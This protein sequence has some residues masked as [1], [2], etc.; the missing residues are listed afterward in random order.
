MKILLVQSYL[1]GH[2]PP[3]YPAGL[4]CLLSVLADHD[5]RAFDPNTADDP[6]GG[7]EQAVREFGP[8]VVG[9]S[10]R[11]IDSTNKR[12]V[13]FY[14][15]FFKEML[16]QIRA[17]TNAPLIVGGSGFSMFAQ[18]IMED[19]PL[20]DYGVYLE[21]ERTFPLLLANLDAPERAPSVFYRRDGK[22][23]FSGG[24][25]KVGGEAL[26]RPNFGAAPLE[27]YLGMPWGVGVETKRG[28][29][30]SCIY[31]PY[32][33]LNGKTY[34]L[35]AP[36]QVADEVGAL[37]A[38]GAGRFTFLDSVFNIPKGHAAAVCRELA[39]RGP[40]VKWS[41]WF[42]ERE[43]DEELLDLAVAAGCDNVILSPDGFSDAALR[44]L[45]KAVR[46]A[47][48]LRA[49]EL[50]KDRDEV[51]VSWNFFKN[52][53]GQTLGAFLSMALF[54]V[55]ARR[56]MG[57]RAHFEFNSLRVEPHTALH[58]IALEEG[59]VAEG[60][61]LLTPVYYTQKRTAYIEKAFNAVLRLAGK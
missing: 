53:P 59:V 21:G 30:L 24:G 41:A 14:Y 43:L 26:P 16:K 45:G 29:A 37:A 44:K 4:A 48:I 10:L 8:D 55:R 9:V 23:V 7:L 56:R 31:C 18:R 39:E 15:Q 42:S 17:L 34:R 54:V 47:D 51:E 28:C 11:N 38:G 1:G 35:K 61:D 60:E 36:S 52:P 40:A 3:V 5:V 6:E 2:E 50:L 13:V 49:Y 33:F 22:A 27:P 20:I 19:E 46:K 12:V 58:G 25:D 32:G 57:R